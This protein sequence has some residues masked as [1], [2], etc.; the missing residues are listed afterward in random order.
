MGVK[1]YRHN[2]PWEN[3]SKTRRLRIGKDIAKM[4]IKKTPSGK[5]WKDAKQRMGDSW[6]DYG[7]IIL[8]RKDEVW[9]GLTA[10]WSTHC[11]RCPPTVAKRFREVEKLVTE[12]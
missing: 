7:Y 9:L 2:P 6:G 12:W 4:A 10:F 5:A 8:F 3:N 11:Y 1:D